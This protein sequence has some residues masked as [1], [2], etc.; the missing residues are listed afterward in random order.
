MRTFG[1]IMLLLCVVAGFGVYRGWFTVSAT[2][3]DPAPG[4]SVSVDK[5]RMRGDLQ[6]AKDKLSGLTDQTVAGV[7]RALDAGRHE[8]HVTREQGELTVRVTP[9]TAIQLGGQPLAFAELKVEDA[10]SVVYHADQDANVARRI[11]V[12]RKP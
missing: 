11:L 12:T 10:V 9:A 3:A 7:I 5:D 2:T 6:A 1:F 8:V 4:A